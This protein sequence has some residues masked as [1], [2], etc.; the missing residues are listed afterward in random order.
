M[1]EFRVKNSAAAF[2]G[3]GFAE[4]L[5]ACTQTIIGSGV[6]KVHPALQ[7]LMDQLNCCS[8]RHSLPILTIAE[9]PCTEA[10]L[11]YGFPCIAVL[12]SIH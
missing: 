12:S 8:L 9:L 10:D 4:Q 3:Q 11:G 7:R 6:K 2:T 5:F 1:A